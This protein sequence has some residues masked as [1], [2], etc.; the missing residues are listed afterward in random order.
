MESEF[1]HRSGIVSAAPIGCA[2]EMAG[3]ADSQANIG[4]AAVFAVVIEAMQNFFFPAPAGLGRQFEYGSLIVSAAE[5]RRAAKIAYR[6]ENQASLGVEPVYTVVIE[7]VQNQFAPASARVALQFVHLTTAVRGCA[8]FAAKLRGTVEIAGGIEDDSSLRE[9]S[10][11]TAGETM[12]QRLGPASARRGCQLKHRPAGV[13]AAKRSTIRRR[14]VKISCEIRNYTAGREKPSPTLKLKL[15]NIVI[16]LGNR[17]GTRH[18]HRH[19][20]HSQYRFESAVSPRGRQGCASHE[21]FLVSGIVGSRGLGGKSGLGRNSTTEA[22]G[23]A[24]GRVF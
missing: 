22:L 19:H 2:I 7:A 10:V 13:G 8:L 12:Q 23:L 3:R 6:I 18:E 21:A 24:L 5:K 20:K 11:G 1:E 15:C 14:P 16:L 17:I 4:T 9:L